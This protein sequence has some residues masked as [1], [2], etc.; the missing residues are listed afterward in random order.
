MKILPVTTGRVVR[1]STV[2]QKKIVGTKTI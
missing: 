1:F 2:D